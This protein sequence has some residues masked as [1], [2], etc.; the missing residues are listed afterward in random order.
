MGEKKRREGGLDVRN[1]DMRREG[2][3]EGRQTREGRKEVGGG[4]EHTGEGG[5][6]DL[7]HSCSEQRMMDLGQR[8]L[9][10]ED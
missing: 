1:E 4:G 9:E 3:K 6:G 2:R 5:K 7:G 10:T 8:G